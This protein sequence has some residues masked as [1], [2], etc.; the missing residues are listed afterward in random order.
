MSFIFV[1]FQMIA[2]IIQ[3]LAAL[4]MDFHG[5]KRKYLRFAPIYLIFTWL[6]NP[7]T[8]VM[9][10]I[11]AIKTISGKGSGKW[12]SPKRKVNND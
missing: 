7:T 2:G 8:I 1:N 6:V 9:T 3:V 12:V 5:A 4:I 10:F 11:Q